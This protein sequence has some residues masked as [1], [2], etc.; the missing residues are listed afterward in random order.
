MPAGAAAPNGARGNLIRPVRPSHEAA[1]TSPPGRTRDRPNLNPAKKAPQSLERGAVTAI[2]PFKATLMGHRPLIGSPSHILGSPPAEAERGTNG[3][4]CMAP[5]GA[6]PWGAFEKG[7]VAFSEVGFA[8][9]QIADSDSAESRR[10]GPWKVRHVSNSG[11]AERLG[12]N[13]AVRQKSLQN[14][15]VDGSSG[16]GRGTGSRKAVGKYGVG[17]GLPTGFSFF[18]FPP[19]S[20]NSLGGELE[21]EVGKMGVGIGGMGGNRNVFGAGGGKGMGDGGEYSL[22]ANPKATFGF[23]HVLSSG[24]G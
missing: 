10:G 2:P 20:T 9:A 13:G 14:G 18:T 21:G 5:P 1:S 22:F 12:E 23:S 3:N 24:S 17:E 19:T 6:T 8:A 16:P 4:P 7:Q 15:G 11:L